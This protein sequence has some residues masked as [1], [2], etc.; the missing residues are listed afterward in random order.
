[1]FRVVAKGLSEKNKH[2]KSMTLNGKPFK[3]PILKHS[4]IV[5]GGELV[6]EMGE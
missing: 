4:E 2:V 5:A 6:F 3:G 1:M